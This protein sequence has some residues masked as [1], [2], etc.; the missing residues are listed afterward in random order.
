M[1]AELQVQTLRRLL[2]LRRR[3]E[4]EPMLEEPVR[5]PIS[6]YTDPDVFEREMHT[7]FRDFPIVAGH[8]AHV[9]EP[10]RPLLSDWPRLPYVVVRDGDGRL[11]AFLNQCRHRGAP[12]VTDCEQ[13]QPLRAFVC[14]YHGWSYGLN[15]ELRTIPKQ[16]NFPGLDR[17]EYGLVELP[18]AEAFGLVWVHPTPGGRVNIDDYLGPFGDDLHHFGIDQFVGFRRSS[19][20]KQANWKLLIK[21]YLEGY[22]VPFLHR[23]TLS[24]AFRR[25]VIAYDLHG[26]H[27][28]LAAARTNVLEAEEVAET[29][30]RI[31]DFASVYY[32]FFPNTFFIM[33]P[34]YVSVN[35]FYPVAADKTIWVHDML[36]EA[37]RFD[38]DRGRAELEKRFKF[39][40]DVVFDNEDFAVAE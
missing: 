30:W 3:G 25:G 7:A 32:S 23:G 18:V 13:E 31:L 33:H 12:L 8:V 35:T 28:R 9:R 6:T 27:L 10:G 14:R 34:D 19:V 16:E 38:G 26:R 15:G 2:A 20:V 24:G 4:H 39:S 37:E 21:T 36:Y 1:R 22:H 11:R 29:D 17:G 40:N 5:I